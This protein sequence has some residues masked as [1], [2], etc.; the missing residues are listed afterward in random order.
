[1]TILQKQFAVLTAAVLLLNGSAASVPVPVQAVRKG[2]V[3]AFAKQ[4]LAAEHALPE[5]PFAQLSFDAGTGQLMRDGI[6]AGESYAGFSAENGE[7]A[8]QR[9]AVLTQAEI[10]SGADASGTVTLSEAA[11]KIGCTYTAE[12]G[13]TVV[14]APFQSATLIV[15]SESTFDPHGGIDKASGYEDLHVLQYPTAADAYHAY[16]AFRAD[17]RITLAEPEIIYRACDTDIGTDFSQELEEGCWGYEAVGCDDFMQRLDN[18]ENPQNPLCVAVLDTGISAEHSWFCGRIAPGGCSFVPDVTD[19]TDDNRHGTFCA[20]IIARCTRDNVKI[21]PLKVLDRTGYGTSVQVYCGMLYAAE[22]GA[23]VI[24][25]SLS[26]MGNSLLLQESTAMLKA[27][28]ISCIAAAGNEHRDVMY[29]NPANIDGVTAVASVRLLN[30][31]DPAMPPESRYDLSDFS[32]MGKGIDFAAPGDHIT[33]AYY[34]TKDGLSTDSG[35]SMAAPFVTSCY[36]NLLDYNPALTPEQIYMLLILNAADLGSQGFDSVFG[37]GM[38]CMKDFVFAD[39]FLEKPAVSLKSGHL[40]AVTPVTLSCHEP[41]A[42]IYYTTDGSTPGPENGIRYDGTPVEITRTMTLKAVAVSEAGCSAVTVCDYVLDCPVPEVSVK[43]GVYDDAVSIELRTAVPAD[44]YYTLDGSYPDPATAKRYGGEKI[45]FDETTL[46]GAAAVIGEM[47]SEPLWAA[48]EIGGAH[49]ERLLRYDGDV[50]TG[51]YLTGSTLD[52]A[53]LAGQ[54]KITAVADGVFA[55][56]SSLNAVMLPDTVTSIGASAFENCSNLKTVTAKGTV[57]LGRSVF[58][59]CSSLESAEL[60]A[61][62]ELPAYAFSGCQ[63]MR[64]SGLDLKKLRAVGAYAFAGSGCSDTFDLPAL[65]TLGCYAFAER[66]SLD[67][68]LPE[69][70]T[71]LPDGLCRNTAKLSLTAPGITEIGAYALASESGDQEMLRLELPFEKL[72]V[73]GE[74]AFAFSD[75]N[76]AAGGQ[77]IFSALTELDKGAFRGVRCRGMAFPQLKRVLSDTFSGIRTEVLRLDCAEMICPDAVSPKAPESCCLIFGSSRTDIDKDALGDTAGYAVIAAPAYSDAAKFCGRQS[78]PFRETPDLF[79][80]E[81][82]PGILQN[83]QTVLTAV[84][85]G[86]G[87]QASWQQDDGA[88]VPPAEGAGQLFADLD[89]FQAEGLLSSWKAMLWEN[90]RLLKTR[91]CTANRSSFVRNTEITK[92]DDPVLVIWSEQAPPEETGDAAVQLS[93]GFTFKAPHDGDYIC[94]AVNPAAELTVKPAFGEAFVQTGSGAA[95]D[96]LMHVR[97]TAGETVTMTLRDLGSR[98][99]NAVLVTE[100]YPKRTLADAL[101]ETGLAIRDYQPD[102]EPPAVTVKNQGTVLQQGT[103][104]VLRYRFAEKPGITEIYAVGI[105]MYAGILYQSAWDAEPFSEGTPVRLTAEGFSSRLFRLDPAQSGKYV[106][107]LTPGEPDRLPE[108]MTTETMNVDLL[109]WDSSLERIEA[110]NMLSVTA[111]YLCSLSA[112]E[113]VYL[114]LFIREN[115]GRSYVLNAEPLG[116][117]NY[118]GYAVFRADEADFTGAE[119]DCPPEVL[120]YPPDLDLNA[121]DNDPDYVLPEPVVLTAG[122]DYEWV[123]PDAL[124]PGDVRWLLTGKG[125]CAGCKILTQRLHYDFNNAADIRADEPFTCGGNAAVFRYVQQGSEPVPEIVSEDGSAFECAYYFDKDTNG[126]CG[127]RLSYRYARKLQRYQEVYIGIRPADGKPHSY[128]LR[129]AGKKLLIAD[130]EAEPVTLDYTGKSQRPTFC[131]TYQG[132]VLTE[133][134]DYEMRMNGDCRECGEYYLQLTGLGEFT[135]T[136]TACC[137]IVMPEP[138]LLTDITPGTT[139]ADIA[140][141]GDTVLYSW[142]P[143]GRSCCILKESVPDAAVRLLDSRGF[144]VG[145]VTGIGRQSTVFPVQAGE[146]YYVAASLAAPQETGT[147][148]FSVA[149]GMTALS[150]CKITGEKL[151]QWD[152]REE[153]PE[154]HVFDG[155]TELTAGCHYTMLVSD[156][157]AQFGYNILYLRGCGD[158]AGEVLYEYY[159]APPLNMVYDDE[160][161]VAMTLGQNVPL[162]PDV[163]GS[164]NQLSFTAPADGTYYLDMSNYDKYCCTLLRYASDKKTVSAGRICFPMKKGET[165]RFVSLMNWPEADIEPKKDASVRITEKV[166]VICFEQNG[167]GFQT[168]KDGMFSVISLPPDQCGYILPETV[169]DPETGITAKFSE[170]FGKLTWHDYD[171]FVGT[172]TIY[173]TPGGAVEAFCDENGYCFSDI[174]PDC[175][176]R[177]DLTGDGLVNDDDGQTL[178]RWLAEGGGMMLPGQAA[179]AADLNG[180]GQITLSDLYEILKIAKG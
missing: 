17:D 75:L 107:S 99:A 78:Y 136:L 28:G 32:N 179:E 25:M 120:C 109:I 52:L 83:E 142:V 80:P 68:I 81:D 141:P 5:Q 151:L 144:T 38:V 100:L 71:K 79:L 177:G 60:G 39:G 53:K 163:P 114:M 139:D 124:L 72:T 1:M 112:G 108:P 49:R 91:E 180:D 116:D 162:K 62:T 160:T 159:V 58:A 9:A 140:V 3:Y 138:V 30:R 24:N 43:P 45:T 6:P 170:I 51:C 110:E 134:A 105:G 143:S 61:V 97:L 106:I 164:L 92:T 169:T 115:T 131:V 37:N 36:A 87:L 33:S 82:K 12:D 122:E 15:R 171:F 50:L 156:S 65:E 126:A 22:L 8:V 157:P 166:P 44:I 101:L 48:Y 128:R 84:P 4:L 117:R 63:A 147:V 29:D 104:Y 16:N 176:V 69:R 67:L 154:I 14:S 121:A 47:Q 20:G 89:P 56:C 178:S 7:I 155:D 26:G 18:A 158:Y 152:G 148:R 165:I 95:P 19:N 66:N 59:G 146:Q 96:Q 11:E 137:T 34:N 10:D 23:D 174:D 70:I 73:I 98:A 132:R 2:S 46:L 85:L 88:A 93:T 175:S 111:Q 153:L 13:E 103:D 27:Q 35:T 40:T 133:N 149:E 42:E 125:N 55:D 41:M 21:L 77:L 130:A 113:P 173:G 86:I 129:S 168:D 94:Y 31:N 57:T 172:V 74:S 135:G 123:R 76:K 102:Q 161:A 118:L 119:P 127:M 54:K 90:G 145:K 167:Y 64:S 150:S